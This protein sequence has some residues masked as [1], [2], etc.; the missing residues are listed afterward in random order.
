LILLEFT[1]NGA[2]LKT[3][4]STLKGK[5]NDLTPVFNGYSQ[6]RQSQYA[7]QFTRGIDPYGRP[8][9]PLTEATIRAKRRRG[10]YKIL[11]STGKLS[12]SQTRF[13]GRMTYRE[14]ITDK[15]AAYLQ[16]KR[17]ILP[18]DRGGIPRSDFRQLSSLLQRYFE[19]P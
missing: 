16:A 15:K 13:P 10:E 3:Y 19:T 12:R 5:C 11:V 14:I 1:S 17:P 7:L 9:A 2:E 18:D 6:F 8:W 4:L